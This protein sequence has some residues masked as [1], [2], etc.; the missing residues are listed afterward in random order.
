MHAL[1]NICVEIAPGERV[2]LPGHNGAGKSTFLK[3]VAGL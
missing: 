3:M 1:S 2:G